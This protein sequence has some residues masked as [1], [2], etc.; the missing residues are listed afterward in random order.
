MYR[1]A[2][3]LRDR[4]GPLAAVILIHVGIGYG[5]LH[6]SGTGAELARQADLAIFDISIAEPPAPPPP[7]P[8]PP[9]ERVKKEQAKPK[10]EEGAASPRNIESQATPIVAPKP[11]IIVPAPSPVV[12]AV[13]PALGAGPTQGASSVPGPGTGAGGSGTGTGSGGSGSGAG[14]GG[15][16]GA[17]GGGNGRGEARA[18]LV[19]P[20]LTPNEYPRSIYRRWPRGGAVFIILRVGPDGV[21]L[22]CR[23][24]RSIGEPAID[25]ETCRLALARFRFE[26]GRD[27]RGRPVA[28]FVGY[29]QEEYGR[30]RR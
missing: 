16:G 5:L 23:I 8:P 26:P 17:G 11:R 2:T 9:V 25:A 13:T 19:T 22:S 3:R 24:A 15:D 28:D 12:A 18:R 6:L 21:P 7:P 30:D 20:P 1:P 14:G 10:R 29:R 4:A 27:E